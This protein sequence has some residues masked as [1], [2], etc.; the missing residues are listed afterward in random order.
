MDTCLLLLVLFFTQ[1]I[2]SLL[3]GLICFIFTLGYL[4]QGFF[5]FI[6]GPCKYR[7]DD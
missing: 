4:P 2:K 3:I 6:P 7:K 1:C 5:Y